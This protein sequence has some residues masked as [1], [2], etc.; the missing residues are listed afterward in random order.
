MSTTPEDFYLAGFSV[1]CS[2]SRGNT[3]S[4]MIVVHPRLIFLNFQIV[5]TW[6]KQNFHPNSSKISKFDLTFISGINRLWSVAVN[7]N[8]LVLE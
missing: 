5:D 6:F 3:K 4:G 7:A 2:M 1:F 8:T